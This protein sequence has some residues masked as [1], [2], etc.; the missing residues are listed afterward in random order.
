MKVSVNREVITGI[1]EKMNWVLFVSMCGFALYLLVNMLNPYRPQEF[2]DTGHTLGLF[3]DENGKYLQRMN[4][5]KFD[6]NLFLSRNL[7]HYTTIKERGNDKEQETKSFEL[8]GVI[9][10]GKNKAAVLKDV[11]D[12]KEYYCMEGDIIGQFKV[13]SITKDKVILE[14]QGTTVEVYR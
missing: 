11:N 5:S 6:E 7:F 8:L 3:E 10:V 2:R 1:V 14:S 9:T 12:K 13:Q 4:V